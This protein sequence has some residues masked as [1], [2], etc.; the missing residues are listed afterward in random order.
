MLTGWWSDSLVIWLARRNNGYR[1]PEQRLWALL[2][3]LI[4][5]V[6]GYL[7]YGWGAQTEAP[8]IVIGIGL[9]FLVAQQG[10]IS[11][12]T[13]TYAMECFEGVCPQSCRSDSLTSADVLQVSGETVTLLACMAAPVNFAISWT[14]QTV[15]DATD[16]GR[17]F[18][19]W[20][21]I[22][23]ASLLCV[24][25]LMIWGKNWRKKSA[26]KYY[27]LLKESFSE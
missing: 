16:Y 8:W 14:T 1:E 9:C 13:V 20:L 3:C 7:A 4:Y 11:N 5:T 19:I 27:R 12:I 25:V 23:I 21:A 26:P 22:S 17:A 10:A 6:I 18:T 15:I 24:P 2:P